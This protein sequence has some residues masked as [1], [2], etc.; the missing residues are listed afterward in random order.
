MTGSVKIRNGTY[1]SSDGTIHHNEIIMSWS[2]ADSRAGF[3]LDRR[4]AWCFIPNNE[5][6]PD[7]CEVAS[8]SSSCSG[9]TEVPEMTFGPDRGSGCSECG[10]TGRI[11]H[12]QWVPYFQ[13]ETA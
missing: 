10:Y 4:K 2:D 11:R 6:L 7:L 3:R 13:G 1:V 5:G 12:T 9:C 8:W